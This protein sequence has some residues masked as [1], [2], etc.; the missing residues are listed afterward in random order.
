MIIKFRH[1]LVLDRWYKKKFF[2]KLYLLF[3]KIIPCLLDKKND[4]IIS[5]RITVE[6][7]LVRPNRISDYY[8]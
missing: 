5:T 8:D 1:K 7:I 6:C 4:L 2:L 3:I